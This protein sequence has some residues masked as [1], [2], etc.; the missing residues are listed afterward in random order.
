MEAYIC[1]LNAAERKLGMTSWEA[2]IGRNKRYK[3]AHVKPSRR[4]SDSYFYDRKNLKPDPSSGETISWHNSMSQARNLSRKLN[5]EE[6]DLYDIVSE[7]LVSEGFCESY[8][9]ADVIMANMS[10]DWREDI[11]DEVRGF[12]GKINP[13]TGEWDTDAKPTPAQRRHQSGTPTRSSNVRGGSHKFYTTAQKYHRQQK[14]ETPRPE[15]PGT[16]LSMSPTRRSELAAGRAARQGQGQRAN[17]IR[18]RMG[19]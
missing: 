18:T 10:E 19:I 9:D 17:K 16:G 8:E 5:R 15:G 11:L 4:K 2:E 7:Y 6:L 1:E 12:G 3:N 13:D 14:Y